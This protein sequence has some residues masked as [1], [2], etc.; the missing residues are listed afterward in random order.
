MSVLLIRKLKRLGSASECHITFS[1]G[2]WV[3]GTV[4]VLLKNE[5][6][7]KHGNECIKSK[8]SC[9]TNEGRYHEII[10]SKE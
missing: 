5:D 6:V 4:H 9:T 3:R 2:N 1:N 8:F 7:L 10:C